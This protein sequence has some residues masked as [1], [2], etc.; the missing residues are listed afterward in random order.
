M[1]RY[2]RIA[3]FYDLLDLPFEY[4]RYRA[5]RPLLFRGLTGRLLD[6]GIG[7]GRN[8]SF[9]PP[10][11]IVSGIDASPAMLARA[12][13]RCPMLAGRLYRMDVARLE[14]PAGAFDAA[15]A[16]FL[17]CVLPDHR[18][19]PA[20]RELGRVVRP[21]GL[22]RLLEY[23]R[24]KGALRRIV[25]RIWQ[26]WIAW[27]YGASFDRETERSIPEA[28]L[29]LVENRYVVADLIKLLTARVP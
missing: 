1:D 3:R 28:G 4:R 26:P 22:I 29:V 13:R 15:V 10:G 14:F 8:C 27:A 25:S 20:L 17:F 9:Y 7:T 16:S 2:Q 6:A 11:A 19:T 21:G 24:P 5:L 12:E 23:V 18:Q